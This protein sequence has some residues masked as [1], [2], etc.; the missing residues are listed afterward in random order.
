MK[1]FCTKNKLLAALVEL[2]V[3]SRQLVSKHTHT[4]GDKIKF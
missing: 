3:N 2:K 1:F 4:V